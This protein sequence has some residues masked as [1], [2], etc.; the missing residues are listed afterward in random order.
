M[1]EIMILPEREVEYRTTGLAVRFD[2]N[3][4]TTVQREDIANLTRALL[5]NATGEFR[6]GI[7]AHARGCGIEVEDDSL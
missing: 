5:M 6:R 7:I 2:H 4:R 3:Q 1:S